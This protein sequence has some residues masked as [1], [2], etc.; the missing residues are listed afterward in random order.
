MEGLRAWAVGTGSCL[1]GVREMMNSNCV[2]F[3]SSSVSAPSKQLNKI[4]FYV[5]YT[6]ART[7]PCAHVT[8]PTYK[9]VTLPVQ[10]MYGRGTQGHVRHS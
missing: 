8:G 10:G 4:K 3:P 7:Y 1:L 5:F 9:F 6:Y 2:P